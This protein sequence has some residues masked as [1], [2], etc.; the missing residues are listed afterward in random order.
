MPSTAPLSQSD[1][2]PCSS[3]DAPPSSFPQISF[4]IRIRLDHRWLG[5]SQSASASSRLDPRRTLLR[6]PQYCRAE[7]HFRTRCCQRLT[8]L[9]DTIR[10]ALGGRREAV[11][12][13]STHPLL[14]P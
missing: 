2:D 9:Q 3:R 10:V 1:T 4:E 8:R 7:V 11:D 5:P 14:R 12:R 13:M 6:V